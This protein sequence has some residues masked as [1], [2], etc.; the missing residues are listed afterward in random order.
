MR[1]LCG[2]AVSAVRETERKYEAAED[3]KLPNPTKAL[4][5]VGDAAEQELT[6]VYF[7]TADL[8]LLR[9]GVTLRRREGGTDAGWHLKLPAGGDSRDELRMPLGRAVRRPPASLLS[10]ARVHTRDATLAPVAELT[11]RRRRWRL[12]D[13][14]QRELAELVDDQVVARVLGEETSTVSWREIEVELAEHGDTDLLDRAEEWLLGLGAQR[15][16]SSSKLGRLLADRLAA[17]DGAPGKTDKTGKAAKSDKAGG[18]PGTAG[19][20]VL[21]YLRAQAQALRR[22]DPLV[23][24][25]APDAVHQMRVA[26][27]RMRSALQ[28]FRRVLDREHTQSLIEELRWMAGE[29]AGARDAEVMA[30]R[31]DTM[32]D[33]LPDELKLGP[34]KAFVDR[35]FARRQAESR[36]RAL[37]ALDSDR[38]LALQDAI[39]ELLADPPLTGRAERPAS[40]ELPASVRR[41]Y[42][43][44]AKGMAQVEALPPGAERDEALHETRKAAKRLRY[45]TEAAGAEGVGKQAKRL[46]KRL[47]AVQDLL[48]EHQD[49]V[50]AR[51]VL[52]ELAAQAHLDGGNGF[53]FGIMHAQESARA[54][55]AERDLPRAWDRLR[56]PAAAAGFIS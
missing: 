8:R 52:R 42:R 44:V 56:K 4:G 41:S 51:P 25:D 28:A 27:R 45:A 21:D 46:R 35:T 23:R 15:A 1:Y 7:D 38:Y 39:D 18:A 40:R 47:K 19:A 49:T 50:V 26:A 6:A 53:S 9:A 3:V 48:G 31:F 29:L 12:V 33:E 32:V 54:E 13:G 17:S 36:E 22:Y 55:R 30:E 43:R 16:A 5:L 37:A 34:V 10:L 2:M 20:T 14:S 24:Q 11:T